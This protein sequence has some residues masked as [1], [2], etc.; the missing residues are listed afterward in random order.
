MA[1][2]QCDMVLDQFNLVV[3]GA[4]AI[5]TITGHHAVLVSKKVQEERLLEYFGTVWPILGCEDEDDIYEA[6]KWAILHRSELQKKADDAYQWLL[7]EHSEERIARLACGT[8]Y[9]AMDGSE[10]KGLFERF[11]KTGLSDF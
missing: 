9:L 10:R 7:K 8:F 1:V 6:V 4:I 2:Q 5:E 3:Y 11:E